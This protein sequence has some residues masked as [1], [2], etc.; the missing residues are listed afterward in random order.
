MCFTLII[1]LIDNVY[2]VRGASLKK[3]RSWF[4]LVIGVFLFFS[5]MNVSSAAGVAEDHLSKAN[6]ELGSALDKVASQDYDGAKKQFESF[7]SQWFDFEDEV[8]EKS[9][10]AYKQIEDAM[11]QVDFAFLQQP[12]QQSSLVNALKN[13]TS[14]N[15]RFISGD[16]KDSESSA[17]GSETGSVATLVGFLKDAKQALDG[18][19]I[20]QAKSDIEKFRK[21]W[22]DI[23]G[24]VLTQSA[25][26]YQD[27]ERDMVLTYAYL[28][29]KAPKTE[30]A[31]KTIDS[32]I[33]YLEP[34]SGKSSYN[35]L[36]AT[37]ILLREGLEA[38]L[39]IVALL[40]FL[41]KSGHED[42]NKWIWSGVG[43]GIGVSL[44]LGILVQILFSAGV[45]G[46]N[47]FLIA[48]FTGIFAAVMLLYM[49]Y[50][51]HSNASIAQWN[52]Y[53]KS[54]STRALAK[55]S[56]WSIAILAFLAVFREGTETVLFLIGM[57]SSITL[58]DLIAGIGIAIVV[59]VILAYVMLKFGVKIP[60]RPFFLVSSLLVF[61]LCF[62]FT[63]M[64]VHGLQLSGFIPATKTEVIP[65]IEFFAVY[66]TWQ[67]IIPQFAL[68]VIAFVFWAWGKTK[69]LRLQQQLKLKTEK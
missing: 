19:N 22:L 38:L 62:K 42:K 20:D 18:G 8:K 3:T 36:D 37:T 28:S 50:W 32:M 57:A 5:L 60:V 69:D 11:G 52:H 34:L 55:G 56:L 9:R 65:S 40:A 33:G 1:I 14:I 41:K 51:L 10:T 67:G 43:A 7:K 23:E 12:I 6:Q 58:F 53:I 39:V 59:I 44:I 68:I 4:G 16:L 66:P 49:T 24:I 63:G 26:A 27:A 29:D 46:S 15:Q 45:F 31:T 47:N 2:R 61:Y 21:S 17:G 48:G 64:G 13:L 30:E 54:R 35:M 25:K